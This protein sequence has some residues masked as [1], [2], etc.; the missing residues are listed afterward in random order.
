M[1]DWTQDLS[2]GVQHPL[3]LPGSSSSSSSGRSCG[4]GGCC[5]GNR[6]RLQ[7]GWG[8]EDRAKE[9]VREGGGVRGRDLRRGGG[10][11]AVDDISPGRRFR[12]RA[13]LGF[14]VVFPGAWVQ[15]RTEWI[16]YRFIMGCRR[17]LFAREASW[18]RLLI[19]PNQCS[20]HLMA[21]YNCGNTEKLCPSK[22]FLKII[23]I[24]ERQRHEVAFHIYRLKQEK[25][26]KWRP[27]EDVSGIDKER[28]YVHPFVCLSVYLSNYSNPPLQW[29]YHS[30]NHRRHS[31]RHPWPWS[32]CCS[33][34]RGLRCRR[35]RELLTD[36]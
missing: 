34:V 4:G 7:L 5:L 16:C 12:A 36:W 17:R 32:L 2:V 20:F 28:I 1:W 30:R 19:E 10:V 13:E 23:R 22:L 8:W 11:H 9:E 18:W 15:L 21:W 31:Y 26:H 24:S 29:K 33:A 25:E 3:V 14:A 27:Y 6:D 35:L